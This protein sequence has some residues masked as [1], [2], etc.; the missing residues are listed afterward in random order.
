M[1]NFNFIRFKENK[2]D[3]ENPPVIR[4]PSERASNAE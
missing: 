1:Q 3:M 4:I 2:D